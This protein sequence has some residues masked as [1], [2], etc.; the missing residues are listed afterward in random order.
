MLQDAT[1]APTIHHGPAFVAGKH[2]WRIRI[3]HIEGIAP[4][5]SAEWR[6]PAQRIGM[7]AIAATEWRHQ[8]DYPRY[9]INNGQTG[10]LPA[11]VCR[12][13]LAV[14]DSYV[15]NLDQLTLF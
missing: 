12:H 1:L 4:S 15:A 13:A 14:Y 10:G 9:D 8:R 6:E 3:T 2:E 7:L 5:W 11:C